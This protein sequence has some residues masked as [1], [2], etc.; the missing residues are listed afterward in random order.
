VRDDGRVPTLTEGEQVRVVELVVAE[1]R[2][3]SRFSRA[4]AA[5]TRTK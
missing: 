2:G 5:T 3:E 4:P 1:A